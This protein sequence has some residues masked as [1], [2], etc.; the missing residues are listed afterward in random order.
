MRLLLYVFGLLLPWSIRR[1]W[2][3]LT[4][5]YDLHPTSRIGFSLL[6]PTEMSLG[7][8][9]RI[10][11]LNVCRR[12][13]SV[14]I[15][16]HV[17]VGSANWISGTP[18]GDRIFYGHLPERRSALIMGDHSALTNRHYVDCTAGVTIG[19]HAT[20]AG[21]RSQLFTHGIDVARSIQDA[22]PVRIGAYSMVGTGAI[23]LA[24]AT[25][26]DHAV[27]AAGSVV[28]GPLDDPYRLYAGAPAKAV[29][30]LPAD[31]AYFTRTQ[32]VVT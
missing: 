23:L 27:V 14:E 16:S 9:S 30:E 18:S 15:G 13:D 20:I 10:G 11:S 5:G 26:P 4:L 2:L 29:R 17:V 25:V 31:A 28:V 6:L 7:E 22:H 32:G 24:G 19:D 21:V 8:H 1:R 3:E 12:I